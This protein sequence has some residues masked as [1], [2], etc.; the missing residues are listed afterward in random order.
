MEAIKFRDD[1]KVDYVQHMGSDLMIANAAYASTGRLV[2][3]ISEKEVGLINFLMK[4]RHGTPFEHGAIT[5]AVEA[6]IF[7]FREFHRHR[8][9]WSYNETSGRY[10]EL[11]PEFYLPNDRRKL[12]QVGKPGAYTFEKGSKKEYEA[13]YEDLQAGYTVAWAAYK[14]MLDTGIAK[15]VARMV[16]PV[17]TYSSMYAT[18]NPRSIMSF[19]ALRTEDESATFVSRPQYEIQLVAQ[20]IEQLF[21]AYWPVTY[22]A[23][24]KNGRVAP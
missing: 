21:A 6:P 1:M 20:G 10:R 4:N 2:H 13:V 11:A 3:Q 15:E 17:A 5:F 24:L 8:I 14:H 7:V 23:W 18:A 19:L 16:L 22:A 12:K 9:G